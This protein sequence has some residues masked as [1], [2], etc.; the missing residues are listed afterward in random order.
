MKFLYFAIDNFWLYEYHETNYTWLTTQMFE[1]ARLLEEKKS[2]ILNPENFS[3][4]QDSINPTFT[5]LSDYS[6][7]KYAEVE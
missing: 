7:D 2:E 6:D 3:F 4:V 1:T 5:D